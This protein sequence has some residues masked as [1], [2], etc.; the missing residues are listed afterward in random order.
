MCELEHVI[1]RE[2]NSHHSKAIYKCCQHSLWQSPWDDAGLEK[3]Q[4]KTMINLERKKSPM[5]F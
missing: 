5:A 3:Q 4:N 1:L 2:S